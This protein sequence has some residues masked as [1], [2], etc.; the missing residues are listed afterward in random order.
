MAGQLIKYNLNCRIKYMRSP[1]LPAVAVMLIMISCGRTDKSISHS[2]M[3]AEH[4]LSGELRKFCDPGSLP[5]FEEDSVSA[6][7]STYDT[8][9]GNDDGFSG[10]FSFIRRNIDGTLVLFDIKGGGVINRIWTPTPTDDTLDFYIDDML[11]PSFS[12]CYT[13]LFSGRRYPFVSPLCGN[14]LGGFYCYLPI[15]FEKSC[16]IVSRGRKEQ[17]HQIQYRLYGHGSAIKS[18]K[19]DLSDEERAS[20]EKVRLL[21]DKKQRTIADFYPGENSVSSTEVSLKAGKTSL[22]FDSK[23]GGRILGIELGPAETFADSG[24]NTDIRI[25]WDGEPNPAVC[26]PVA[27][28]FGFAFGSP[29]MQSLLL[30]TRD[31]LNYCYFPMPFDRSARIELIRRDGKNPSAA[32][33]AV[34]ATIWYSTVKRDPEHEGKFYARWERNPAEQPGKP[35][36]FADLKGKGHYVGTILQAQ[37]LKAGMTLFFEGD[38]STAIDGTC[39]LHG[40]GSEDYFNG[41]W[42]AM[43]DRWDDK[44]SLPLHGSLG[45]SLP[46]CRTGGYRLYLTDKLSF[47]KSFYHSI[48]HGPV[49]N[50]FPSDY[51]SVAFYYSDTPAQNITIPTDQLSAVF[52]PDTLYLYPQLCGFTLYGKMDVETT[53]KYGTGGESYRFTPGNESWLRLSLDEIPAGQYSVYLDLINDPSGCEFS[54]WQ[55]QKQVSEWFSTFSREEMRVR[56]LFISDISIPET[57]KTLTFRFRTGGAA[58]SLLVNR[59]KLIKH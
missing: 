36:V 6:E 1:F 52:I 9:W 29:A 28:F 16:R 25:W 53:W 31:N 58:K 32:S 3:Q 51:T 19:P 39:R 41:G 49:R 4:S 23:R 34:K 22:L 18:F 5:V 55:R 50:D 11:S 21:W 42:Y 12:I 24:K 59:I 48:E 46:F 15:P 10:R 2:P 13:D 30:G 14:E 47:R 44:M 17:F 56:E 43:M 54:I 33:P 38:D 45:Y 8:T 27:D 35:H 26:C 20:L 57:L 37:G 7:V 40:T